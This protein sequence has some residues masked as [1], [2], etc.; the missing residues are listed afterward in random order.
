MD[1]F[2][3]D[4]TIRLG[5][6][7]VA[8]GLLGG[9]LLVILMMRADMKILSQRVGAV[10]KTFDAFAKIVEQR[11]NGIT[12][13]LVEQARHDQRMS[14]MEERLREIIGPSTAR[15]NSSQ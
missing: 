13:I 4:M 8:T 2:A 1:K 7:I 15:K 3:V 14:N 10:E 11:L 9:G 12:S 5:D 6:I